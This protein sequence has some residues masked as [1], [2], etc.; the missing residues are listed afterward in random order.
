VRQF[1]LNNELSLYVEE[2]K[3]HCAN[4]II[5]S[6]SVNSQTEFRN[7]LLDDEVTSIT[8]TTENNGK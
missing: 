2:D 8:V 6:E 4:R 3:Y 5:Y 1:V 7:Q